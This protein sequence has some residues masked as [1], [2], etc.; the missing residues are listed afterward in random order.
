MVKVIEKSRVEEAHKTA[1][2]LGYEIYRDIPLPSS[3][4]T[5]FRKGIDDLCELEFQLFSDGLAL[6]TVNLKRDFLGEEIDL[7]NMK[8][9][10]SRLQNHYE[11]IG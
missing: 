5:V 4:M 3:K 7:E 9:A 10:F 2:D 11:V 8:Q 1:I 6:F